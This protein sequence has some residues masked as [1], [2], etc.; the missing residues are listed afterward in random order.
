MYFEDV[1]LGDRVGKAGWQNVYVPDA[2]VTHIGGHSTARASERML[3]EHH[4]S[5]YKY[6]A[7]RHQGVLWAP[8][9]T[10]V[11]AGLTIR[12]KMLTRRR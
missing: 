7:D 3:A 11:K 12:V 2:E 5:A 8:F 6:L 9:R 10:I 1:D 4:R